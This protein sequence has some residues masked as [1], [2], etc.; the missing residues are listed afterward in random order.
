[1][2]VQPK[3]PTQF[4]WFGHGYREG[5]QDIANIINVG[6]TIENVR[7]WVSNNGA[8]LTPVSVELESH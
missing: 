6:G 8:D 2:S 3:G 7:E 1:M 5:M 4:T